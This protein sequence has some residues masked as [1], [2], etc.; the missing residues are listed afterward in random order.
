M[1][2]DKHFE[3]QYT[4]L[5][6]EAIL[7]S[8]FLALITASIATFA[9]ALLLWL[10]PLNGWWISLIVLFA[11]TAIATVLYFR[12][13][14]SPTPMANARRLDRL[15]LEE[16]LVTMVELQN[17]TSYIASIQR[18][19]AKAALA[20]LTPADLKFRFDKNVWI[21]LAVT[22]TLAV[23]MT[24][25]TALGEAGLLPNGDDLIRD[26]LP[27]QR[28][29]YVSITY[30]VEDGGEIQ[31]VADQ[32]IPKGTHA[33][34]VTAVPFDGFTFVGWDDGGTRPTRQE[35]DV[36]EDFVVMAVFEPID[37][38][39]DGDGDGDAGDENA[40]EDA[41]GDEE[42]APGEN[43]SDEAP[44]GDDPESSSTHDRKNP[45]SAGAGK[46]DDFNQIIDGRTYYRDLLESYRDI[47]EDYL[48]EYGDQLTEEQRKIIESYIG[49]V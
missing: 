44:P 48:E 32:L 2:Q 35:K 33:E 42:G 38:D 45:G 14:Y 22:A 18:E 36:T 15:G 27:E 25:F 41:P 1:K 13:R 40:S 31:G 20:K 49:I 26:L 10:T 8:L 9:I 12:F 7:R 30:L 3:Q 47:I 21:L 37:G 43:P 29:N 23:G 24:V 46:Y 4:K 16:R 39:G 28:E 6:L 5:R 19:D 34:P 11:V 17:E